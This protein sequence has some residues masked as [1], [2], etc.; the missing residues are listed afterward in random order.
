MSN[1]KKVFLSLLIFGLMKEKLERTAINFIV[2]KKTHK[3]GL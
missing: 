3:I 2:Y 1:L